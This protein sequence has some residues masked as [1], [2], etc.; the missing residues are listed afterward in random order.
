MEK[1]RFPQMLK[2]KGFPIVDADEIAR[3]VVEPGSPVLQEISRHIWTKN[4]LN[5]GRITE[6]GKLGERNLQ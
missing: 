5:A 1:V 6:S 2:R 3:L 4:V